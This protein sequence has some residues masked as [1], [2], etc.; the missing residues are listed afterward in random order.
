MKR[1]KELKGEKIDTEIKMAA[2]TTELLHAVQGGDWSS[3]PKTTIE[4][5]Q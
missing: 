5:Q 3:A 2:R 4:N 1:I